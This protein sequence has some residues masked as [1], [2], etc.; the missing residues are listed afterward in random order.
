MSAK[1]NPRPPKRPT[2]GNQK[3]QTPTGPKSTP[4]GFQWKKAGRTSLVWISIILLAIFLSGLFTGAGE[5]EYEIDYFQYRDFLQNKKI[6]KA[7]ISKTH[8]MAP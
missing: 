4:P 5:K 7:A 6:S 8:F 3:R 1:E 2:R